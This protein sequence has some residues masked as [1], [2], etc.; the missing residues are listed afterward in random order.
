[1]KSRYCSMRDFAEELEI[2]LVAANARIATLE[3]EIAGG[4]K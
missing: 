1:M 4:R 3:L 2:E